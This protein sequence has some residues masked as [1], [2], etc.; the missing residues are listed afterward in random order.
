MK[1]KTNDNIVTIKG[2]YDNQFD[3]NAISSVNIIHED[4][5]LIIYMKT[6]QADKTTGQ[7]NS[8]KSQVKRYNQPLRSLQPI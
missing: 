3:R 5:E 2:M 8:R 4:L 1:S 6:K 7:Q